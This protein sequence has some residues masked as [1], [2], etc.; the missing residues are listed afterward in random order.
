MQLYRIDYL[1]AEKADKEGRSVE[2]V[3]KELLNVLG[4]SRQTFNVL[5]RTKVSNTARLNVHVL[6][7]VKY[8]NC[9]IDS[10]VNPAAKDV[11]TQNLSK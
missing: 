3:T 2:S 7:L 8:F 11:L 10:I 9:P 5:R 4:I 1:I 6:R